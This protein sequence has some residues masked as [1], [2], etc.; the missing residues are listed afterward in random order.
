MTLLILFSVWLHIIYFR[1]FIFEI[2]PCLSTLFTIEFFLCRG[3]IDLPFSVHLSD[4]VC[5][6]NQKSITDR[7]MQ[8]YKDI[9]HHV[10]LC[11]LVIWCNCSQRWT[12]FELW[13]FLVGHE[14][15]ASM[16]SAHISSFIWF[17]CRLIYFYF[18]FILF[19]LFLSFTLYIW[20]KVPQLLYAKVHGIRGWYEDFQ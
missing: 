10:N 2:Y 17:T 8:P 12:S 4:F 1:N 18:I 3:H 16:S 15:G 9:H 7:M 14:V 19:Q 13:S 11:T 20:L 6:Y 5:W